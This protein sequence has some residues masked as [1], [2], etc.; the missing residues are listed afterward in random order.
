M[1][2]YHVP[3]TDGLTASRLV[4]VDSNTKLVSNA[5]LTSGRVPFANGAGSLVDSAN[6]TFVTDTLTCSYIQASVSLGI[7]TAAPTVGLGIKGDATTDGPTL[8]AEFLSAGGWTSTNWTGAWSTGWIHTITHTDVLSYPTAAVSGHTYQIKWTLSSYTTGSFTITF[9][10]HTSEANVTSG[11]WL[12]TTSST[13]NLQITPTAGFD[14]KIVLSVKDILIPTLPSLYIEDSSAT[15]RAI[16]V[17]PAA[18]SI[19][20]GGG[21]YCNTSAP[22][23]LGIGAYA[24]NNVI[25][26]NANTAVGAYSLTAMTGGKFNTAIGAFTLNALTNGS[27]NAAMGLQ[28]LYACTTGSDNLAIGTF[29]LQHCTTGNGNIGI[30]RE[31]C[32]TLTTGINNVG[33]GYQALLFITATSENTGI[34]HSAGALTIAGGNNT[35]Q[36]NCTYVGSNTK[37]SGDNQVQLG[38]SGT[39]TYAYGAVQ[40]RSDERDKADVKDTS[41][42][43]NF[44]NSL[45]PVDFRRDYREDYDI[46]SVDIDDKTTVTKLPKDGS[47]KRTRY[48]HGLIAQEVK[49]TLDK[50]GIDFGGYQDH[51]VNGGEDVLSLGYTEF[52][53]PLVKAVQEL[54]ARLDSY[55]HTNK[56]LSD[57]LKALSK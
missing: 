38:A 10:G 19:F 9:G 4:G 51:T 11:S 3:I 54:S 52:I 21:Q 13:G 22:N 30:G 37:C 24:L 32:I 44:I 2:A 55:Q 56:V 1:T 26:G 20:V 5:A 12:T 16:F 15:V 45:H 25:D 57:T 42:G 46:V 8:A 18:T 14:G 23:N 40:D 43:L 27:S 36:T 53:G 49:Q 29:S 17:T 48:H 33:I 6:M 39:T 34:G 47:K 7:A 35:S 41:L 50:L 31:G 28:A